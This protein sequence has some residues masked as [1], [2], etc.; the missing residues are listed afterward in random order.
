MGESGGREFWEGNRLG[1]DG[2]GVDGWS[3]KVWEDKE[4]DE[5]GWVSIN[6]N[7]I[8]S[9]LIIYSSDGIS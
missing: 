4:A 1:L 8:Y 6:T 2:D 5:I 3:R 7:Y 9:L